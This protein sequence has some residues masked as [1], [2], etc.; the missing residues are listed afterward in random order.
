MFTLEEI[1]N[2]SFRRAGISGYKIEDVDTFVDGVIEKVRALDLANKEMEARIEQLNVQIS[3]HEA[4]AESVQ[5]AIITAEMT[6]KKLVRDANMK[7]EVIIADANAKAENIIK[8]AED[9]AAAKIADAD[10]RAETILDNALSRSA[11]SIDENNRIIERQK[12]HIKSIQSEVSRFREALIDSYKNHIKI[13]NTLPKAEE[14]AQYQTKLDENYPPEK[15]FTPS[16]VGQDVKEEAEK[17]AEAARTEKTQIRVEMVNEEK[18]REINDEI[19]FNTKAINELE[20]DKQKEAAERAAAEREADKREAAEREAA[21]RAAAE[22][23]AEYA[24]SD[25]IPDIIELTNDN[26]VSGAVVSEINENEDSNAE[27]ILAAVRDYDPMKTVA[28]T[29]KPT[30]IDEIDDGVVF[31]SSQFG[32]EEEAPKNNRQPI[33][34]KKNAK[35]KKKFGR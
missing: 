25:G 21:D 16:S 7:S 31:S 8:E 9:K 4:Q 15:P 3:K 17:A 27:D 14:F 24:V 5:D 32:N 18:V 10:T 2:V 12:Q 30:S 19:R 33:S 35:K 26:D 1:E 28:D 34:M 29:P 13:I 23:E 20:S 6:A 22:E 11:S